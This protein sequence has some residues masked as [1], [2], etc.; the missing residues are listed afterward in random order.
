MTRV[1]LIRHGEIRKADPRCFIGRQDLPLTDQGR[2]QIADDR[3]QS[4]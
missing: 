1:Y 4:R 3:I 2:L